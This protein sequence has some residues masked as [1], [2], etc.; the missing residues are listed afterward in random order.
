MIKNRQLAFRIIIVISVL[1]AFTA[2]LVLSVS[3]DFYGP[4]C[5]IV[6]W[7]DGRHALFANNE[8]NSDARGGRI[9]FK[10]AENGKHGYALFGY[11]VM[12]IGDICIG[13]INDQGL[14]FDM[15]AVPKVK[16]RQ[17]TGNQMVPGS[18]FYEILEKGS[19]VKDVEEL[20][21]GKDLPLL[22]T[23]QAHFADRNG[24]GVVLGIGPNGD[25]SV[26]RKSGDYLISVNWNL[27]FGENAPGRD[28]DWR[29]DKAVETIKASGE[30]STSSAAGVLTAVRQPSTVYSYIVDIQTSKAD[31]YKSGDFSK[32][33]TLDMKTEILKGAHE[34]DIAQLF[35]Q[36]E[37]KGPDLAASI[38]ALL[39]I[40]VAG[41]LATW[42][43]LKEKSR[44]IRKVA[45]V[46]AGGVLFAALG[47]FVRIP[48]QAVPIPDLVTVTLY[49]L[50]TGAL[51]FIVGIL[52]KPTE[53]LL[54][55]FLGLIL[56]ATQFYQVA[57][58]PDG[59]LAA[60][61]MALLSYGSAAIVVSLLR[62][63]RLWMP[64]LFGLLA[65]TLVPLPFIYWYYTAIL[66]SARYVAIYSLILFGINVIS[67]PVA[68]TVIW[69]VRTLQRRMTKPVAAS[70]VK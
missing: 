25:L 21:K 29:Y 17:G 58:S 65:M 59:V 9:W 45:M 5:T 54:I 50:F 18:F 10:P 32:K 69:A 56:G 15:N 49:V 11:R 39:A 46:L 36:Q 19:T 60:L 38:L 43:A 27:A 34:Y 55:S 26:T 68:L 24:D 63:K 16:L 22:T 8:D 66:P 40:I 42:F 30:I 4:F 2:G 52:F 33:V 70:E 57:G 67:V 64:V 31:F 47:F 41:V 37:R 62:N 20:A 3:N 35:D 44:I 12:S 61:A 14:V 53:A 48:L 28:K 23:Q 6:T 51:V 13:G 1:V 7:S